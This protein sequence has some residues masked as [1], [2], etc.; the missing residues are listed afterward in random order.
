MENDIEN[1]IENTFD[2]FD[3]NPNVMDGLEAMNFKEPSPIQK[4]AIPVILN[5]DDLI[6]CAQTGTGKTAA[7]VLPLLS[8]LADGDFPNNKV[9][10]VI[11]APTR[12]LAQ[13]IDNQIQG[14]AYF[15]DVSATAVYGGTGGSEWEQ[16]RR[17]L[18]MG[19]DIVVATPGRLL[20]H[21]NFEAVDLSQLSFFI[22]DEADRMLDMG[23][24]DDIMQIFEQLPKSCQIIMFSATMPANIRKLAA[25]IM[26]NPK[27]INI[28]IS[29]PPTSI[30]QR[31]YIC[32]EP[33]KL[34][35]I[36][37]LFKEHTP[38][39][40][41]I[42]ASSKEKVRQLSTTLS[43]KHI[44]LCEMHSD[45][46]QSKREEVM[47]DF[48]NG[49]IDLLVA[50]DIVARGI[51]VDQIEMVINLDVPRDPED[52][53][54]RIGRTA[55][56]DNDY[57]IAITLV[58]QDEQ[59]EFYKI[60]RFLEY[61]V[62][63]IPLTPDLGEAPVYAPSTERSKARRKSYRKQTN[64][65]QQGRNTHK[66]NDDKRTGH[67]KNRSPKRKDRRNKENG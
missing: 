16:Q 49:K 64:R 7:Y 59:N 10:A 54:H 22:L 53:V 47:R 34:P 12:E 19:V 8:M 20:S 3:L 65:I 51:D 1:S 21:L 32:Y 5:G 29:K 37:Q 56:G 63:K 28:A 31:A 27:Q 2:Q 62:K 55:R 42:F 67:N 35:I 25:N 60:E 15:V 11:M 30:D 40:S 48:K 36:L 43:R 4:L 26:K 18:A 66:R 17:G 45:L 44:K 39:R 23:F 61:E 9:N 52:Y 13:Q 14:F 50:T 24:Y 38:K 33:Q 46:D 41:I 57:G 58:G 6:A